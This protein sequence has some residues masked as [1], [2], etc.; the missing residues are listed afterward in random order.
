MA[1]GRIYILAEIMIGTVEVR[2]G[3][4]HKPKEYGE[5]L[6]SPEL[7]NELSKNDLTNIK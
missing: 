1:Q 7:P 4:F 2:C 6:A 3:A 5:M